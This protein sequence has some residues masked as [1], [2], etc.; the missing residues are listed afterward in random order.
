MDDENEDEAHGCDESRG[1]KPRQ[2]DGKGDAE[3]K[4]WARK[5]RG[6]MMTRGRGR[7]YARGRDGRDRRDEAYMQEDTHHHGAQGT[8]PPG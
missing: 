5:K 3:G 7:G 1:R 2:R 6:T 4:G 8:A